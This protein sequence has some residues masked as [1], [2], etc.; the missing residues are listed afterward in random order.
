MSSLWAQTHPFTI[1]SWSRGK[2]DALK[3]LKQ[4]RN[5]F[6][7]N[8]V[9]YGSLTTESSIS[10]LTLFTGP[11]GLTKDIGPYENALLIASGLGITTSIPYLR[12]YGYNTCSSHIRRLH[13]VWQVESISEH[14][15]RQFPC[16]PS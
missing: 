6:S 3:L 10:F 9:R 13:F 1:T 14:N 12:I 2:Q 15:P 5:G 4:P 11:H 7:A 8:L 16:N